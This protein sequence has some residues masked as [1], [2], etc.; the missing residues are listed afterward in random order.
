GSPNDPATGKALHQAGIEYAIVHTSLPPQTTPP[1]QPPLPDDSEPRDAGALNPWFAPVVR[2]SD[3][4][5]YRI[6]S[7]PRTTQGALILAGTG[8]GV[9]ESDGSATARWLLEP[10][11][12]LNLY[13]TG[14]PR[15]VAFVLTL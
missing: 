7:R 13:L 15:R 5:I 3:A 14:R 1:Y 11:G 2:T 10:T 6:R 4:V 8:F 12:K 9:S